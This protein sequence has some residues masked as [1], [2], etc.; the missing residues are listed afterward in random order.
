MSQESIVEQARGRIAE[1]FMTSG[2]LANDLRLVDDLGAD[3]L[4]L[5]HIVA[6]L[7]D[8]FA[9]RIDADALPEMLNVGGA[10]RV[11][12]RLVAAKAV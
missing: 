1:Y 5:L 8:D 2:P 12:E 9:I 4:D 6:T 10:C 3:S 11:V 7:E